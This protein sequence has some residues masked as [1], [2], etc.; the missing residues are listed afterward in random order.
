MNYIFK[1][2][3]EDVDW[4]GVHG[5]LKRAGMAHP[6][7]ELIEK[8]FKNSYSVVFVYDDKRLI[9]T[10]RALSDGAYQAAVYDIA[11]EPSYQGKGLGR[12]I[13]DRLYDDIKECNIILYSRPGAEKFYEK[14][15]FR[16]MLT[17]M[18]LF[19]NKQSMME[20]GFTE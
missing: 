16:R 13:I 1:K 5:L 14:F 19:K 17:G 3:C 20:R 4:N 18:A 9:G 8:A 12:D 11:V 10:G 6:P 15:N 7:A 2:N